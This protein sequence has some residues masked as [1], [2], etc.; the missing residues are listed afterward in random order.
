MKRSGNCLPALLAAFACLSVPAQ[1]QDQSTPILGNVPFPTDENSPPNQEKGAP[2]TPGDQAMFNQ[3]ATYYDH[4][5]Y[6]HAYQ[7]FYYLAEHDDIA[8][9]RNV[10]LMKR[11]GQGTTRDPRG[12]ME[13]LKE[14]AD[15]G[16]PTAQSDLADMLLN[17]EAGP[18]DPESA[19]QWLEA[20]AKAHHPIAEF[21]LA[22]IY[23][24]GQVVPRDVARAEE[25]YTD[26]AARGV[27]QAAQ[28]LELL[29]SGAVSPPRP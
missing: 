21:R 25:L 26:A 22:E 18:P 4:G 7:M 27:P 13:Y 15:A 8:A 17:G 12:A 2:P 14:A 5:D 10:A 3:G 19:M 23:E 28:R 1:A 16:L 24:R 11:K 29:K 6:T 20:A 9:M